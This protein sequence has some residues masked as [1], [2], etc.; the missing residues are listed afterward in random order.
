[1]VKPDSE[2]E[3]VKED[4]KLEE[5]N[6]LKLKSVSAY[7]LSDLQKLAEEYNIPITIGGK[8]QTKQQLYNKLKEI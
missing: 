4:T 6:Q 8:K 1:M 5:K 2:S 3:S 7:K